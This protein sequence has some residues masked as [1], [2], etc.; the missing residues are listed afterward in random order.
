MMCPFAFSRQ[1]V[2]LA[3]SALHIKDAQVCNQISVLR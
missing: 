2:A 1:K 3:A